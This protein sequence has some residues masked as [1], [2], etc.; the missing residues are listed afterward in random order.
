MLPLAKQA[1]EE[2]RYVDAEQALPIYLRNQ[3]T[4]N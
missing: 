1:F 2:Q 4:F 3:V